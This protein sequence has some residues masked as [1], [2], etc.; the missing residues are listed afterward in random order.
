[1]MYR[2]SVFFDGPR[3]HWSEKLDP[4]EI[5]YQCEV[6]WLWLARMSVKGNIGNKGRCGYVIE[7][8]E[9]IVEESRVIQVIA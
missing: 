2:A 3:S 1:M 7:Q 8:G 5:I 9:K 6:P 4:S